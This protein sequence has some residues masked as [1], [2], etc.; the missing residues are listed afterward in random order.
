MRRCEATPGPSSA[1]EDRTGEA[2][3]FETTTPRVDDQGAV[4]GVCLNARDVTERKRGEQALRD[5]E[6][7][8]RDLFDNA[9]D[10]VCATAVDGAFLYANRAWRHSVGYTDADLASRRF[11]D[12]VHPSGR[13]YYREVVGR[14]LAGETLTHVELVLVTSSGAPITVEGNVSATFRHGR[15]EVLRGSTATSPSVSGS[16]QLRRAERMQAAGRLAAG[17]RTK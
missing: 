11:L 4:I 2:R 7:R 9:S 5:S 13:E 6:A 1:I 17:W 14:A 16:R 8:Y 12:M 3:W 15:P 10:L